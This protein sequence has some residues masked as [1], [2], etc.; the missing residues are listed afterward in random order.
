MPRRS[1][2]VFRLRYLRPLAAL[3]VGLVL[4]SA[5]PP[6]LAA[7]E[8]PSSRAEIALSFA[9][10]VQSATPAVVN[11]YSRRVVHERTMPRLFDDPVFRHFFGGPLAPSRPRERVENALGSGV[12]VRPNGIILTNNHVI[13][14]ADE[15]TVVLHDRREY[16]ATLLGTD[17]RTDL[18]VLSID[19]GDEALPALTLGDSDSLAVG[20]LVLAIGNPFGVGQTVTMGIVSALARSTGGLSD[21]QSFI[22]TDAA[23]N[24]GNSG[25]ALV[26]MSG[27]LVGINTAIY[28]K[29]GG[30]VGIGFAIP[31]A[32]ARVVVDSLIAGKRVTRPWLGIDGQSVT[33]D[34]ARSLGLP[35]PNG[36][37][38][39]DVLPDGP[40]Q[41]A[42]LKRGDLVLT[43]DG[44]PVDDEEALRYRVG[45]SAVGGTVTLHVLRD[46]RELDVAVPLLAPPETPPR[47][48]TQLRGRHPFNG[49]TVANLNPA[50]AE[51][52]GLPHGLGTVVVMGIA[53]GSPALRIGLRPGDIVAEVNGQPP[54]TVQD[55]DR[56]MQRTGP[57]WRLELV[58]DGR[59]L[60]VAVGG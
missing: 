21:Y 57:P 24:P 12:I 2:L 59:R 29:D 9:P 18:A 51:E 42:G 26:D 35:R 41:K 53:Q 47:D 16:D 39:S 54:D 4:L 30:N 37:L 36:V 7:Q 38:L 58:R 50:L 25:G 22:Q 40:G 3:C 17:E 13:E 28:S 8:V 6:P 55:L 60:R 19:V 23:I 46:G 48:T 32:M 15:I 33:S 11:I 44:H 43:Y 34:I 56:L 14:G 49:V 20:D 10:V 5:A 1:P 31:S 27:R 52:L 45:A